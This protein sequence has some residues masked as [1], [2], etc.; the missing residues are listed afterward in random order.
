M[1]SEAAAPTVSAESIPVQGQNH[2]TI[3]TATGALVFLRKAHEA[4]L[5]YQPWVTHCTT[6]PRV[7]AALVPC[8]VH[9]RKIYRTSSQMYEKRHWSR[10]AAGTIQA[11]ASV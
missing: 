5:F 4:L 7:N 11:C 10:K 3:A 8:K 2:D 6:H 9:S 1:V